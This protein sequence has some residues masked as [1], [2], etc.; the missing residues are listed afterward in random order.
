MLAFAN[1]FH[2]LADELSGLRARRFALALVA[3][4]A[5]ER[6][7]FG[8]RGLHCAAAFSGTNAQ[9]G[10]VAWRFGSGGTPMTA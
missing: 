2:F 1:V 3:R 9:I 5:L 4:G 6:F 10:P 7:P 8:H